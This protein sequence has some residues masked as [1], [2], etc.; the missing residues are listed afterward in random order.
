MKFF[1]NAAEWSAET[2]TNLG[3]KQLNRSPR[4]ILKKKAKMVRGMGMMDTEG[5]YSMDMAMLGGEGK[6]MMVKCRLCYWVWST[7]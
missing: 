6:E 5:K 1:P 4:E 2:K 7:A 3:L